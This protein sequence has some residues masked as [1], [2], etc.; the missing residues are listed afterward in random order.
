MVSPPFFMLVQDARVLDCCQNP[1]ALLWTLLDDSTDFSVAVGIINEFGK[2]EV[3]GTCAE[4]RAKVDSKIAYLSGPQ[5]GYRR[6]V[7]KGAAAECIR[8]R[9]CTLF[10]G[11]QLS[12]P[13]NFPKVEMLES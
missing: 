9:V 4:F 10:R 13:C 1:T 11:G 3:V 8:N 12:D 2:R 7:S 6:L 5:D